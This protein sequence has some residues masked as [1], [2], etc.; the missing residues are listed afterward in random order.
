MEKN[1]AFSKESTEATNKFQK[2]KMEADSEMEI[3][4][5][6]AK[7]KKQQQIQGTNQA[8]FVT[9]QLKNN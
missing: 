7:I 6:D 8:K 2:S 9:D 4:R 1:N 5:M 3:F